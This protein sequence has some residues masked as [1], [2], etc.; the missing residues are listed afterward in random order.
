MFSYRIGAV[1][2]CR[3]GFKPVLSYNTLAKHLLKKIEKM[4]CINIDITSE[5]ELYNCIKC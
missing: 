1:N 5:E 3:W 2:D 4:K